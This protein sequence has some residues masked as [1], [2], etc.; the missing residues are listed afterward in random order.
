[1]YLYELL[2]RISSS[3]SYVESVFE[4]VQKWQIVAAAVFR[5]YVTRDLAAREPFLRRQAQATCIRRAIHRR[6]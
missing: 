4:S 3:I 5:P 2:V 1:M 6:A